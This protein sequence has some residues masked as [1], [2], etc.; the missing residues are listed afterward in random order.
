LT[1]RHATPSIKNSNS[2]KYY[3]P[4]ATFDFPLYLSLA[5]RIGAL[6]VVVWDKDMIGKEYL[7]EV[8]LGITE[9]FGEHQKQ[10]DWESA[11]VSN[12]ICN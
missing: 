12:E 7:G 2:P 1:S 4:E 5:D 6:E 8:A 11:E 9:W 3:P 10:Y